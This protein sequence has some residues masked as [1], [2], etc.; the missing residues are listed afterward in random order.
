[1]N[2]Q[3][4]LNVRLNELEQT[5][6]S[7]LR[8][9]LKE[10]RKTTVKSNDVWEYILT[11]VLQRKGLHLT[12]FHPD[13]A[14]INDF[15]MVVRIDKNRFEEYK[16]E[17]TRF[18]RRMNQGWEGKA[19]PYPDSLSDEHTLRYMLYIAHNM[20]FMQKIQKNNK[21]K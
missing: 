11:R 5:M 2:N 4:K 1:M 10:E 15:R 3:I 18:M 6:L 14:S 9:Y 12:R 7:E 19:K 13:R 16:E 20:Y 17:C 21:K 8:T